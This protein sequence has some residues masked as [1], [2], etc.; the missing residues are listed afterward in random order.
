MVRSAGWQLLGCTRAHMSQVLAH[1][2]GMSAEMMARVIDL[3]KIEPGERWDHLFEIG[4]SVSKHS[5]KM[6]Y[7]KFYGVVPY[8][9]YSGAAELRH[10]EEMS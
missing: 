4:K 6:N 2:N 10:G 3:C 8:N 1:K 5:Q 7:L 9:K